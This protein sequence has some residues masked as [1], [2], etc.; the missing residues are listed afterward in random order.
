MP[1]SRFK[2]FIDRAFLGNRGY[3]YRTGTW[4]RQGVTSGLIGSIGNTIAPGAGTLARFIYDRTHRGVGQPTQTPLSTGGGSNYT[5]D[6]GGLNAPDFNIRTDDPGYY[7]PAP[8]TS[9]GANWQNG[10]GTGGYSY[11]GGDS[12][13]PSMTTLNPG[14]SYTPPDWSTYLQNPDFTIKTGDNG[15]G[16]NAGHSTGSTGGS[17]FSGNSSGGT[18]GG[19][20]A[21]DPSQWGAFG[22][23]GSDAGNS[24]PYK[25][26]YATGMG[27]SGGGGIGGLAAFMAAKRKPQTGGGG[28]ISG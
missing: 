28:Q 12:M 11:N 22:I 9:G 14:P 15:G 19:G 25:T 13:T 21:V 16:N 7:N 1:G 6:F 2:E 27:E 20:Y 4:N 17:T 8:S 24:V 23:G 5:P 10:Y 3:D 18:L 26:Q